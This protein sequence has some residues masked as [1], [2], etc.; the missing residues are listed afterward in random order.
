MLSI[1]INIPLK[2]VHLFSYSL[3]VPSRPAPPGTARSD[4][5]LYSVTVIL[6]NTVRAKVCL[7]AID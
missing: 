6:N 7:K 4:T 3:S 1:A 5:L 2:T